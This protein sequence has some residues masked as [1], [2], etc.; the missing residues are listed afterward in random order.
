MTDAWTGVILAA[1]KGA[2]MKSRIPKALH[3][4]C[5]APMLSH[6]AAAI[7]NA[8]V[9]QLVVVADPVTAESPQLASAAGN[10]AR[11]VVQSEPLGTADALLSAQMAC[12]KSGSVLV[13]AAD[14]PL[15]R[16][17]S[18]RRLLAE[19]RSSGALVTVLT[20]RVDSPDGMGR[21]RRNSSGR[22]VAIVEEADADGE[23]L[24]IGRST[25][26]GTA[27]LRIGCGAR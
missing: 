15:V 20:A 24:A 4:L 6:V 19:H 22:P 3:E 11:I 12:E 26:V 17:S 25:P 23:S 14:M 18:V 1:G 21:I 5:G 16:S 10:G 2:R 13:G 7:R 27:L 8:G 9:R